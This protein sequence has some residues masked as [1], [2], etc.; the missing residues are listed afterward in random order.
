MSDE[1]IP[2][3]ASDGSDDPTMAKVVYALFLVGLVLGGITSIIGVI[4]AYVN[5]NDA[6]PWLQS[7]YRFQIRTFWMG[8]LFSVIAAVTTLVLIGWLIGVFILVWLIVR[9]VKGLSW[10]SNRRPVENV[11]TW[12]FP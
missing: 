3:P 10:A 2:V 6:A 8:L 12:L 5:R 11:E 4:L 7:H 9:C 1:S